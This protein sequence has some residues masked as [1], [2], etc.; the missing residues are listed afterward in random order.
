LF[1]Y[2]SFATKRR[3]FQ[4]SL[5]GWVGYDASVEVADRVSGNE[6]NGYAK[7][8]R[9]LPKEQIAYK[10][11]NGKFWSTGGKGCRSDSSFHERNTIT[12]SEAFYSEI[13]QHRLPD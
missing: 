5:R 13:D 12:L 8:L 6:S 4:N 7:H 3:I 11:R 9:P 1:L 2:C 10:R